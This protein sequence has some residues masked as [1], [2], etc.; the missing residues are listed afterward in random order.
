MAEGLGGQKHVAHQGRNVQAVAGKKRRI[1][2][3]RLIAGTVKVLG[4]LI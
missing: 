3:G 1:L 4:K 2:S